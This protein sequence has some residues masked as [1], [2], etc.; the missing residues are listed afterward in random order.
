[1]GVPTLAGI[2][3]LKLPVRDLRCS[4]RWYGEVLGYRVTVEFVEQGELKGLGMEHPDGGPPLALRLDPELAAA[5]AGF[6]YFAYGVPDRPGIEALA[7]RLDELG[8][9]HGGVHRASEGWILPML[10]DPDGH[11]VRFYP[12]A[13]HEDAP[14]G[15]HRVHD[16]GPDMRIEPLV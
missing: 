4:A 9:P 12:H 10:H 6:D 15:P 13:R 2:H 7:A 3:H 1:M 14:T 16:P 8:L 11:E 5:A